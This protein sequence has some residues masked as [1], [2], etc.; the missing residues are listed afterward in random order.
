MFAVVAVYNCEGE[1]KTSTV[2]EKVILLFNSSGSISWISTSLEFG[3]GGSASFLQ[4]VSA[5]ISIFPS[6]KHISLLFLLMS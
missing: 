5:S 6:K 4:P 2:A 3:V 1:P